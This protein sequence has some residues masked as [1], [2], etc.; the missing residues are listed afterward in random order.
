VPVAQPAADEPTLAPYPGDT[1]APPEINAPIV[2]MPALFSIQFSNTLD[3]WGITATQIVRTNDGG[4]T[5]YNVTP[6][7]V[8]ETGYGVQLRSLDPMHAWMYLP[9]PAM[10]PYGGFLH[11]TNDGGLTWQM[12]SIPFSSGDIQMLNANEGWAL[13]DLG[14]GAGSNAVAVFQ[15]TDGGASWVQ[16]YIN[17]PNN[18]NAGDS[19]PLGGLKFGIAPRDR[20]TAWV[21]GVVYAPGTA[22]LYRTEDGG[23]TWSEVKLPLPAGAENVELSIDAGQMKFV[24]PT[25]GYVIVRLTGDLYQDAVYTS[26]DGGAAWVLT[27]T[28]IPDGGSADFLSPQ[29]MLIYNGDQF[30]VTNDAARTWRIIP[31]DV[32]FGDTF[33]M[34]DFVDLNTGWVITLD[35]SDQRTLY[36]T[37]DGGTTWSPLVP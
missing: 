10:Y 4:V 12:T 29:E 20:N 16:T 21:Y 6:A 2:D 1:P 14:G 30:Y 31:P 27:L 3:G 13:A 28:P 37:S 7:G 36:R 23:A 5:W 33:A 35:S 19:L 25:N 34:M 18:A 8:A 24:S 32:I 9:D 11:R 26:Q 15:T 22:Y 17:D